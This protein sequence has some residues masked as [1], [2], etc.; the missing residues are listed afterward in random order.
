MIKTH[1]HHHSRTSAVMDVDIK[2][3][4]SLSCGPIAQRTENR[5]IMFNCVPTQP[6]KIAAVLQTR[7]RRQLFCI[8][9]FM[10][11]YIYGLH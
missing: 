11:L 4:G 5:D 3:V 9:C 1:T 2:N 10:V 7:K 8:A 6:P